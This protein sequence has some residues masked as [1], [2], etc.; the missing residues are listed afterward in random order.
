MII[1]KLVVGSMFS[2]LLGSGVANADWGDVYYCQTTHEVGITSDGEM[3]RYKLGTF[4]FKL[5]KTRN[6]MVFGSSGYAADQVLELMEDRAWPEQ[7]AW[8]AQNREQVTWFEKGKFLYAQV[9]VT[10]IVS[11]SAD[12]DKF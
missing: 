2:M 9:A 3:T 10:E 4:Q 8:Y 11:I 1:K 6:A 12:C 5:D 7:E